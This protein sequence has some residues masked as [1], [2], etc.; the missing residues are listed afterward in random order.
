MNKGFWGFLDWLFRG[1]LDM[2]MQAAPAREEDC[3]ISSDLFW[4]DY[5]QGSICDLKRELVLNQVNNQL[6]YSHA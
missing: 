3:R 4:E 6:I 2:F 1:H 5:S